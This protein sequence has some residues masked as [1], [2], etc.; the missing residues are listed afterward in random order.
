MVSTE[1]QDIQNVQDVSPEYLELRPGNAEP[2]ILW[3]GID[4]KRLKERGGKDEGL[5]NIRSILLF[6]RRPQSNEREIG[7][8]MEVCKGMRGKASNGKGQG[9]EEDSVSGRGGL[10]G[11]DTVRPC[12]LV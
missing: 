11:Q 7:I 8:G 12:W 10:G 1:C 9:C 6:A 4:A 5:G 2:H 3:P